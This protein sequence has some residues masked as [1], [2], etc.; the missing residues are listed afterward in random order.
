[1]AAAAAAAAATAP[2]LT[3]RARAALI[4]A[5]AGA[6]GLGCYDDLAGSGGPRGFRGHLGAL[7][8]GELTTGTIKLAGIGA[9]GL[10][11]SAV[12]G[13]TGA[14][15]G[16]GRGAGGRIADLVINAGLIAGGANLIN[17]FDLRPGRAAKVALAAG[18]LLAA[19]R[20]PGP[21]AAAAPMGAVAGLIGEDLGERAMLG[22]AGANAV[23]AM[24]GTAAA[25]GLP[26]PARLAVLALTAGLTAVSEK[27][28]FTAVIERTPVLRRLDMLGRR[29]AAAA[30]GPVPDQPGPGRTAG[31]PAPGP[32]AGSEA[33]TGPGRSRSAAR[34]GR[35]ATAARRSDGE[36]TGPVPPVTADGRFPRRAGG[37]GPAGRGGPS[38]GAASA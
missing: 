6:G 24:L 31:Q 29:P 30:G 27:V 11:A 22:D 14:A 18:G 19:G 25:A 3:P 13:R 5:G 12:L 35:A 7:A 15:G 9:T 28:S 23:G 33:G 20:A 1:V 17:L 4:A 10:A 8:A 2:G 16:S 26:R 38:A 21:Q 37:D 32:A 34:A 36:P